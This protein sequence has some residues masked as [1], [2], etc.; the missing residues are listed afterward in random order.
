[1][2]YQK[3]PLAEG[4]KN[5][6]KQEKVVKLI[7]EEFPL[8]VLDDYIDVKKI[9]NIYCTENPTEK[10][11]PEIVKNIIYRYGVQ[12]GERFF[13]LTEG[14]IKNLLTKIE[15][16]LNEYSILY[17][18]EL[19]KKDVYF[20]SSL[21]IGDADALRNILREV[22]K[23]FYFGL[24][25]CARDKKVEVNSEVARIF[26]NSNGIELSLDYV[27]QKLPYV[28]SEKII[29]LLS[30]KNKYL[31]TLNKRYI[32][33]TKIFLD[34]E[35]IFMAKK[36]IKTDLKARNFIELENYKWTNSYKNNPTVSRQ[37]LLNW[38]YTKC[39]S[40]EFVR[41]GN[42]LLKR[43]TD[44]KAVDVQSGNKDLKE[45]LGEY[46]EITTAKLFFYAQERGLKKREALALANKYMTRVNKNLFVK[47]KYLNFDIEGVDEIIGRFVKGKIIS[48]KNI[49]SFTGFP[50]PE[51]YTWNLYLLE[52]FLRKFSRRYSFCCCQNVNDSNLGAIYPKTMKVENYL[53]L[54][55]KVILQEKIPLSKES[56]D[57]F[58][59]QQGYRSRNIDKVTYE[60]IST[61]KSKYIFNRIKGRRNLNLFV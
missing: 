40:L 24:E 45:I 29:T 56:V 31:P 36:L 27:T 60:I 16:L 46:E 37:M 9:I 11:T 13:L 8:G 23:K 2:N 50:E 17:Y 58:L 38:I 47:D 49:T 34:E 54:Q 6:T 22:N 10:V 1:M 61:A 3:K 39:F 14:Q 4:R 43:A 12:S 53:D 18:S 57:N 33:V 26:R 41:Q 59:K 5:M 19:Y 28:P 32:S 42:R 15:R 30:D 55:V 35:E 44:F 51:Y 25:Y 52:S 48:L 7:R 21:T 20:F